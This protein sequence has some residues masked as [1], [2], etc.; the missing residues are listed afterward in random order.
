MKKIS[1]KIISIFMAALILIST[2]SL[3]VPANAAAA[4]TLS[5]KTLTV[6]VGKTAT[7]KMKNTKAKVTWATSNK[8]I[9]TVSSNGIIKGIKVG[10]VNITATANKKKYVCKVTVKKAATPAKN[11]HLSLQKNQRISPADPLSRFHQSV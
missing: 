9:A 2:I 4:P 5:A 11:R 8:R 10:K 6:T 1:S 7:L 3:V